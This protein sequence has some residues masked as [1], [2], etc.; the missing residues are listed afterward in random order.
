MQILSEQAEIGKFS[1]SC[2]AEPHYRDLSL[3]LILGHQ[4]GPQ[5]G[6]LLVHAPDD[7]VYPYSHMD[8]TGLG[9]PVQD[10]IVAFGERQNERKSAGA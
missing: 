3:D 6:E 9:E 5:Y 10:D 2:H 1:C 7:L 8:V 4:I